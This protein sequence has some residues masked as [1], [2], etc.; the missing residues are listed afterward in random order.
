[1]GGAIAWE[2]SPSPP[3]ARAWLRAEAGGGAVQ[4][5]SVDVKRRRRDD[6]LRDAADG[7]RHAD[8][9]QHARTGSGLAETAAE[10][11]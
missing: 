8:R 7:P 2:A 1:M 5:A 6:V 11:C 10:G 9:L 3:R 4:H